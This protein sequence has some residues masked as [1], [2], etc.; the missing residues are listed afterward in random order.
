M[1]EYWLVKVLYSDQTRTLHDPFPI[2]STATP[3]ILDL[4]TSDFLLD[5]YSNVFDMS[6]VL[7]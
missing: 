4:F 6:K 5:P 2:N 7:G 1:I 3:Q